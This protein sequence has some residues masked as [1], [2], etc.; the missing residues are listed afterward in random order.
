VELSSPLVAVGGLVVLVVLLLLLITSRYK[1]A[2][3]NQAYIV[4]GRKG[5]AV[6]N[7]DLMAD[8]AP[9]DA[10]GRCFVFDAD[11]RRRGDVAWLLSAGPNGA[12]ET[13]RASPALV[14][15]DIG[16]VVK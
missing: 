8:G 15:D 2:G 14:G 9:T 16:V 3:P 13:P 4:T 12:I 5:K 11:A 1:V 7:P 10:W 6:L